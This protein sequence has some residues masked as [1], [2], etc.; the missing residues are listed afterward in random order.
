MI[1]KTTL[2]AIIGLL[3][4][5]YSIHGQK[6]IEKSKEE[7]TE[8]SAVRHQSSSSSSSSRSRSSSSSDGESAFAEIFVRFFVEATV[9]A[10]KYGII[11]D[12]YNEDHLYNNL[13]HYPY[14]DGSYGNFNSRDSL[15][16]SKIRIDI[17]DSFMYSN[18]NLVGNHFKAKIRP[19]QYFYLQTDLR[20]VYESDPIN[21]SNYKLY[22]SHFTLG[23]DRI[24]MD[25]FNLGWNLGVSYIGNDV[26]KTGFTYG[27]STDFFLDKNISFSGSAKWSRINT[28]PVNAFELQSKYHKKNYYFSLGFEHLKIATPTYNFVTL[29]AGVY[30]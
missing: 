19:F 29:G 20:Q 6:K 1:Q 21:D 5:S 10:F 12:Y 15:S 24:R 27:I 8:Q 2:L 18:K 14:K 9:G 23:Y 25:K 4:F 11:G 26:R 3:F 30:F 7:L 17:E 16:K 28:R 13:S 22:F